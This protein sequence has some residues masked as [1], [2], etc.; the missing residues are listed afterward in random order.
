MDFAYLEISEASIGSK[1][2]KEF[3]SPRN[4]RTPLLFWYM[5]FVLSFHQQLFLIIESHVQI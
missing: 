3:S 5:N 1:I 2:R 4:R